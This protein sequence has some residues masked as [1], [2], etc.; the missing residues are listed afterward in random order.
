MNF[1]VS[2]D[3]NTGSILAVTNVLPEEGHYTE[4]GKEQYLLFVRNE[5]DYGDFLCVPDPKQKGN[6]ILLEKEQQKN[7]FDIDKS[8][9]EFEKTTKLE[10][11]ADVMYIIQDVAKKKWFAKANLNSNY[12]AFL[13]QT[14]NFEDTA[15]RIFVTTQNNPNVL[16]D[17]L[18]I[19]QSNFLSDT[20]FEIKDLN[21][22]NEVSL[23]AGITHETY[24]HVIRK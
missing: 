10:N 18:E 8:I 24:K 20:E 5:Q 6:F 11:E 14:K 17:V 4:I 15:K 1:Y 23:Y 16:L 19:D 12:I 22:D 2:F 21:N 7:D 3:I 13:N 9:H